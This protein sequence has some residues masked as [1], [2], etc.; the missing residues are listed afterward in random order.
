MV[1]LSWSSALLPLT[2]GDTDLREFVPPSASSILMHK[3]IRLP[4]YF[5]EFFLILLN[6]NIHFFA[7]EQGYI[8]W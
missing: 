5:F 2:G 7:S 8:D 1:V 3:M 6:L 4:F